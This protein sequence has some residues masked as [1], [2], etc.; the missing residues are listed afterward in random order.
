MVNNE[1]VAH[2]GLYCGSCGVYLATRSGG[3]ELEQ[4]AQRFGLAPEEMRCEGC[5]SDVLFTHCRSCEFRDCTAGKGIENCEDCAEWPCEKLKNFQTQMP[6]RAELFESAAY[7]KENGLDAWAEKMK[8]DYS[9][10]S[11]GAINSPYYVKCKQCG[12]MPGN[13]FIGRNLELIEKFTKR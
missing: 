4:L 7:R 10:Q 2:C 3:E 9:C 6:H 1:L 13:D 12:N 11:C 8:A 5:S